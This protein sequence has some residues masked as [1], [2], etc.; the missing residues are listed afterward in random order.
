MSQEPYIGIH[1][2]SHIRDAISDHHEAIESKAKGKTSI[3]FWIKSSLADDIRMDESCTHKLYPTGSLTDTTTI[4]IAEWTREVDFYAW[5]DERE[6]AWSHTDFYFFAEYIREHRLDRELEMTDADIFVDDNTLH[7]VKGI[8]VRCIHILVTKD[9]TGDDGTDW[10][11]LISQYQVLHTR[12]LCGEDI[13]FSLE[14]EGILH[15]ASWVRLRD[16]DRIEV[17]ILCRDLHRVIDIE[18][19]TSK[20]ILHLTLYD[21]DGMEASFSQFKWYCDIFSLGLES[22]GDELALDTQSLC[23]DSISDDITDII[24]R[25]SDR[26][27]L[28]WGEVFESLEDGGE[29]TRL[30]E[31]GIFVV[32]ELVFSMDKWELF[33]HFRLEG[34]DLC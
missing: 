13:A 6:V 2:V 14:P 3:D 5:L 12:G 10:S 30:S 28:L 18:S 16:I 32:D 17:E 11:F 20:G 23:I 19:H 34:L 8:L 29:A 26:A 31:D 21:R 27:A 4:A 24:G 25:F 15:I 1:K 7:L 33:E 9:S 22:F